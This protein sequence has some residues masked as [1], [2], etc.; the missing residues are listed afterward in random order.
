MNKRYMAGSY[1]VSTQLQGSLGRQ[2]ASNWLVGLP[3]DFLGKFVPALQKVTAA[4]VQAV[5]KKYF[6]PDEQSWVVVGDSSKIA[7][8]LKAFGEFVPVK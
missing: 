2:L 1:L 5:G 3:A 7:E 4:E 6:N 8:Q